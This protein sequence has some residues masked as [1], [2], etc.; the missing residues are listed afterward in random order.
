[1]TRMGS[2]YKYCVFI[3]AA[4]CCYDSSES[5]FERSLIGTSG[6]YVVQQCYSAQRALKGTLSACLTAVREDEIDPLQGRAWVLH[7]M[8]LSPRTLRW[9]NKQLK[10]HCRSVLRPR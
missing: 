10:W 4:D 3:I 2:I 8:A 6:E 9:L 1:M 7:E 5:I